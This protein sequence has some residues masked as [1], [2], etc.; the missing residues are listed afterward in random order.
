MRATAA[1][2][3]LLLA[4]VALGDES[5]GAGPVASTPAVD[6]L[7][8]AG[9]IVE[10]Q[11]NS[12]EN[13][14]K[15]IG[16]Y[17]ANLAGVADARTKAKGYSDLSRA[18]LRLGDL[19]KADDTK[20]AQYTKGRKAAE[21]AIEADA[22]YADGYFWESANQACIGNTEGVMNS[23]FMVSDLK[24]N[25]NKVLE[26]DPNHLYAR[27][28]L[29][30]IDHALPGIAGGSDD[31]AEKA[32][33]EVLERDPN[34]TPAMVC[35]AQL[36]KDEG[37]DHEAKKWAQKVIDFKDSSVPNDWKKFDKNDAENILQAL[38]E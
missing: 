4:T 1:A 24:K 31:R 33:R 14:E 5:S 11:A 21:S 12:K 27:D 20:I 17:E 6:P 38:D 28:T 2:F 29:G 3:V 8:E 13:L 19:E 10:K 37:N 30:E 15:A 25:L 22:K 26:L 9:N 36:Y 32:Y 23:L 18:Y 16:L 35:L 34:F 7:T